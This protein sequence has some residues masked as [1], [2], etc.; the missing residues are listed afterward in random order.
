[1]SGLMSSDLIDAESAFKEVENSR[2]CQLPS[3]HFGQVV[4]QCKQSKTHLTQATERAGYFWMCGHCRELIRQ[5]SLVR[6]CYLD[7]ASV[8]EHFHHGRT[9]LRKRYVRLS[10]SERLRIQDK[11]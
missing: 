4:G 11:V 1:M 10:Q 9:N 2:I 7:A 8:G 6:L 3:L 5:C